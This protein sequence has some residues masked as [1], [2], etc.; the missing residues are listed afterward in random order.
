M[1]PD[2]TV[3]AP[4]PPPAMT[5]PDGIPGR[6]GVPRRLALLLACALVLAAAS[7]NEHDDAAESVGDDVS[8]ETRETSADTAADASHPPSGVV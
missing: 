5:N 7:A 3:I 8:S 1:T 2:A 4:Q 6:P